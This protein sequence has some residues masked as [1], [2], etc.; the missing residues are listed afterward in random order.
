MAAEGALCEAISA[1][2]KILFFTGAGISTPS[3]IPDF[4]G[5]Q[6]VWRKRD[7]VFYQDFMSSEDS[8]VDYWEYKLEGWAA[9]QKA[10]PNVV[11]D[12]IVRIEKAGKLGLVVTQN[13]DGL[14]LL[15]GTSPSL[16]VELH[17]TNGKVECQGCGQEADPEESFESF[18]REGVAPRCSCGGYLKP[19]TISF[20][21]G[22]RPEDLERASQG[23]SSCDLI[24]SLGSTL[25]VEPAASIPLLAAKSG[26]PYFIVN[27]GETAHDRIDC[28]SGRIDGL[29]E[30]VLPAAVEKAL[31][32]G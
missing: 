14:H 19:A 1:A 6:G 8:R 12:A 31:R 2:G 9:F 24:L 23:A 32:Q 26:S 25:S 20:G 5:P 7:P 4:R 16:L 28:L 10:R 3:G 17:G 11:H 21:Q 22:L 18:R 27:R 30:E 13:V 15:A 29:V